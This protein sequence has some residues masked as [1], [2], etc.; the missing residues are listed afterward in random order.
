MDHSLYPD[1]SFRR[2]W[3]SN[4]LETFNRNKQVVDNV[5]LERLMEHVEMFSIA[6]HFF[7]GVWSIVQAAN[8]SIP[9]DFLGSVEHHFFQNFKKFH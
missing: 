7:W 4:Y 9:F 2:K 8:S 3:I 1:E 5:E 6:A